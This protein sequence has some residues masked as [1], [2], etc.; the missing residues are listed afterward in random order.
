MEKVLNVLRQR[1]QQFGLLKW[2]ERLRLLLVGR[3][4]DKGLLFRIFIYIV[5]IETAYL[6]LNPIL[7]MISNMVKGLDDLLDPTVNWIPKAIYWGHLKEAWELLN[8]PSSFGVSF[9]L[10]IGAS[11]FQLVACAMAGYAF[12]RVQFPFKRFWFAC[13]IFTFVIP[14]QVTVLP[15]IIMYR[16]V[17]WIDTYFPMLVPALF[18]HGLKGALYVIIYRQ[19]FS[20]LP[21]EL[22]EAAK[23]DGASLYRVF[24][25]VMLPI[26]TPAIVVVFLFS[27]VWNWNDSYF[28]MMFLFKM[29]DVPLSIAL[30]KATGDLTT[31]EGRLFAQSIDMAKSFLAVMPPLVLYLFTQRWFVEGVER[32]GLVE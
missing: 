20:I 24:F 10:S 18:G 7:Y 21:K 9:G 27:F 26:A 25:K 3:E 30:V 4:A 14:P 22:E 17:G 8:Y 31:E 23:I 12:A 2:A 1:Q 16:E 11:L 28:P 32:T 5:L 29:Q 6:Y 13:L 15:L 19:F